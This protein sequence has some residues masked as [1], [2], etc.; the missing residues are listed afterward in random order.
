MFF[1]T[2]GLT[3]TVQVTVVDPLVALTVTVTLAATGL[4]G[5]EKVYDDWPAGIVSVPATLDGPGCCL[6]ATSE[7]AWSRGGV[8]R[9]E[10]GNG[11]AAGLGSETCNAG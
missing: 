10:E 8:Q 7:S 9:Y 6:R 4:V 5:S 1:S 2:A 11:V 3:P